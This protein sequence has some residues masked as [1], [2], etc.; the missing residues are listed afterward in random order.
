MR[1]RSAMGRT[2]IW[3]ASILAE[4]KPQSFSW[5]V[6]AH[7]RPGAYDLYRDSFAELYDVADVDA[8]ARQ[9]F[10]SRTNLTLFRAG[11]IAHGRSTAQTLIRDP[12]LIRRSGIDSLNLTVVN[13]PMVGDSDGR[14]VSSSGGTVHLQDLSRPT[15]SRWE[16]LHIVNLTIPREQVARLFTGADIHG[17]V[18]DGGAARLV[19]HHLQVMAEVAD[20][21]TDGEG[22]AAIQAALLIVERALGRDPP[23]DPHHAEAIRRTVRETAIRFIS[24]N[25]LSPSLDIDAITSACA[26]SRSTLYRAFD[27]HGGVAGQIQRMR[28][29]RARDALRLRRDGLPTITDV[30]YDLGFTSQAHFSRL[31]RARFGYPP[32]E[33]PS[34]WNDPRTAQDNLPNRI[35]HGRVVSWLRR[36]R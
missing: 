22:E 18:L 20:G 24:F 19:A 29:E 8:R 14:S 33:E 5:D 3:V 36:S 32:S 15:R 12:E 6:S 7:D 2:S 26:V 35:E 13:S 10:V 27:G 4:Y 11:V 28:L 17:T 16:G 30:A 21:L 31:Y 34:L 25:L 1:R 23:A 9:T